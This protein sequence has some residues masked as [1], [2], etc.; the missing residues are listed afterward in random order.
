M[1]PRPDHAGP[2]GAVRFNEAENSVEI[3]FTRKP[4]RELAAKL[5]MTGFRLNNRPPW[6]WFQ[7]ASDEAWALACWLSGDLIG[8]YRA[9]QG[10]A[11][12]RASANGEAVPPIDRARL[13]DNFT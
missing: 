4:S 10:F 6:K 2:L 3:H 13:A 7:R 11:G 8:G 5:M 9:A 1:T 12:A